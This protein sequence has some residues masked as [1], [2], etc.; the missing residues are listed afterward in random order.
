MK[1]ATTEY[2][3]ERKANTY[4]TNKKKRDEQQEFQEVF[5]QAVRNVNMNRRQFV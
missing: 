5:M 2:S 4:Y 1:V 3:H